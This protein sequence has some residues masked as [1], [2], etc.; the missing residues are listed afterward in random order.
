MDFFCLCWRDIAVE[1][2]ANGLFSLVSLRP[3]IALRP[4]IRERF[5]TRGRNPFY[6]KLCLHLNKLE[7]GVQERD[8]TNT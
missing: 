5:F 4:Q 1:H 7:Y 2:I 8:L 3:Y 6:R